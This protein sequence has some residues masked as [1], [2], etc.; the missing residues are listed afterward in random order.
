MVHTWPRWELERAAECSWHGDEFGLRSVGVGG[1][2][3]TH[4]IDDDNAL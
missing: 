1:L 4:A 3:M 2:R